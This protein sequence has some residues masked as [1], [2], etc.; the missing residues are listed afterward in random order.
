M[1]VCLCL[2]PIGP[3]TA[4]PNGLKFGMGVGMDHGTVCVA[5]SPLV[6]VEEKNA[7]KCCFQAKHKIKKNDGDPNLVGTDCVKSDPWPKGTCPLGW[8]CLFVLHVGA[9]KA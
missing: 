1:C 9:Q 3:Q 5:L 6:G 7:Q 4:G 2:L 8:G